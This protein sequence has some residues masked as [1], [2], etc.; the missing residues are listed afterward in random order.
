MK[1]FSLFA[2]PAASLRTWLLCLCALSLPLCAAEETADSSP[3][4]ELEQRLTELREKANGGDAYSMRQLYLRYEMAGYSDTALV[5]A[6]RFLDTLETKAAEG[7]AAAI[8]TLG[9]IYVSGDGCIPPDTAKAIRWYTKASDAG[10]PTA[11]YL[12]GELFTAAKDSD[13]ARLN[14]ARAYGLYKQKAAEGDADALY[15]QGY[16]EQN[17][18]GTDTDAAAG[19]AH[20]QQAADQGCLPAVYQLFKTYESGVGTAMDEYAAYLCAKRLADEAKDAQMAYLVADTLLKGMG[21]RLPAD[22]AQAEPYLEQ[23]VNGGVPDALYHKAWLLEEEGKAAEALSLYR[24]AASMNHGGAAVKAGT[25][26]LYGTGGVEKDDS[27]GLNFLKTAS[28]RLQHPIAPYELAL[29]YDSIGETGLADDWYVTA[30]DRGL[31]DAMGPR[32][33]L[34]LN[35][36]SGQTWSPTEAYRWWHIGAEAG[37]PTC[38]RYLQLYLYLFI[39]LILIFVFGTP[40]ALL[41]YVMKRKEP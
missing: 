18:L 39:P 13:N 33:L 26:L 9:Q 14:Y 10:D 24:Q 28:D 36:F 34:H 6:Q 16:M 20:L 19:I 15:R 38:R 8:R 35:P 40:L 32:G 29:Y 7:D 41:R 17:G 37:E 5:W 30:S 22:R 1:M 23:A 27:L 25:M 11:A 31:A 3:N 2:H 4:A 12:L 21:D